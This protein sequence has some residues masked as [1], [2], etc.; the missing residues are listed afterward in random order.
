VDPLAF[1]A[2]CCQPVYGVQD[3]LWL[4]HLLGLRE[5]VVHDRVLLRVVRIGLQR[6]LPLLG[7]RELTR[8]IF[9]VD[10]GVH[11]LIVL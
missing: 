6:L 11:L 4:K 1:L 3:D 2:L 7:C 10:E 9:R 8:H 5:H